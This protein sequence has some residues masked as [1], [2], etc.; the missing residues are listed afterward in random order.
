MNAAPDAIV[1]PDREREIYTQLDALLETLGRHVS[2][3]CLWADRPLNEQQAAHLTCCWH[4]IDAL[5][6]LFAEEAAR[7][8]STRRESER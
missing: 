7:L 6:R 3:I 1:T 5:R 8:S 4:T 2:F